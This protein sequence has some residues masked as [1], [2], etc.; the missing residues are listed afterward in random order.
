MACKY[1]EEL[2]GDIGDDI[3]GEDFLI[4]LTGSTSTRV[5]RVSV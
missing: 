4:A 2:I 1:C 3:S 5:L